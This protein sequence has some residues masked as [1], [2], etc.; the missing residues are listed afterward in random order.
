MHTSLL[1][2]MLCKLDFQGARYTMKGEIPVQEGNNHPTNSP[3]GVFDASDGK[4]NL[5]ASTNKMFRAFC[6]VM[7]AD[8][9]LADERFRHARGR[10]EHRGELMARMNAITARRPTAELVEKL[11]AVGC[12]CGPIYDIGQAF[13]DEQARFL[14]MQRPVQHPALGEFN[15][16]RSPINLSAFAPPA[17]FD[18]PG[19]E[20]GEHNH[21]VLREFGLTD[22]EIKALADAGAI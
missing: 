12:P 1:E 5:A 18:R 3:M 22:Q 2:A 8:D 10:I 19:P 21:E 6:E 16:V 4:I 9:L 17:A 11:N 7:A 15:L 14:A 20:L 13:E